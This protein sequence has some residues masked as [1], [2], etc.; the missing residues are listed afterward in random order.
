[1]R[2]TIKDL[3]ALTGMSV[4]AVSQVLNGKDCRIAQDK[5]ELIRETAARLGYHPNQNA[6]ALATNTTRTIGVILNDISNIYFAEFAKGAENVALEHGYQ[7][8]LVNVSNRFGKAVN[9]AD[10]L[11]YDNTDGIIL[12]RDL[13]TPE[14]EE[15]VRTYYER[16]KPIANAGNGDALLPSGNIIFDDEKGS[17][18]AAKHLLELGHRRIGC[19]T[20]PGFGPKDRIVGYRKALS[21]FGVEFDRSIVKAGNYHEES[22]KLFSKKLIDAGVTAIFTFNDLMSYGVYQ[23]AQENNLTI[24]DDL[25]V[26][27]FDDL[28]FSSFLST[29]LTTVHQSACEMGEASCRMLL[30]MIA[31]GTQEADDIIFEPELIIRKSTQKIV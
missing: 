16:G 24:P 27:G 11:G 2:T 22:G 8:L 30:K 3:A 15:Y 6:V 18:L 5:K 9:Y 12:T 26:V 17:Y 13:D 19:I 10:V 28:R 4:T 1:M 7:I 23:M 20:G 25:S 31:G 29:P 21:E 14:L